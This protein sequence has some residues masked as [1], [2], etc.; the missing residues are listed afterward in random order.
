MSSRVDQK[1]ATRARRE[2]SVREEE[3]RERR[4]R[5][6]WQLGIALAAA[7]AIVAAMIVLAL[8]GVGFSVYLTYLELFVIDAIC[9]WDVASAVIMTV[10]AGLA[11]ARLL[12]APPE[13]GAA[14]G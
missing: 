9:Q 1:A 5:T 7:A 2:A 13:P 6:L 10:P 3:A 12:R 14:A 11:L 8:T 4:R